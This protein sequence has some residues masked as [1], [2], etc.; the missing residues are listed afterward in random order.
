[1]NIVIFYKK[2]QFFTFIFT[3]F[4]NFFSMMKRSFVPFNPSDIQ[5]DSNNP[6]WKGPLGQAAAWFEFAPHFGWVGAIERGAGSSE[7]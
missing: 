3:Y 4:K 2:H 6:E 5:V 7:T 1:M